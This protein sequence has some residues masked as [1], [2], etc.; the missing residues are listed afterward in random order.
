MSCV[1][2]FN[3]Q[4]VSVDFTTTDEGCIE[5]NI[6]RGGGYNSRTFFMRFNF[7]PKPKLLGVNKKMTAIAKNQKAGV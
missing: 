6:V 5:R 3:L 1:R 7:T 2:R 4:Y